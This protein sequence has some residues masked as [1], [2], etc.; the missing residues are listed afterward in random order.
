MTDSSREPPAQGRDPARPQDLLRIGN[1][2]REQVVRRIHDA[3]AEGRLDAEE[4]Q[5]RLDAAYQ[6]KTMGELAPLTADLPSTSAPQRRPESRPRE[7]SR[8]RQRSRSR[9]VRAPG[10]DRLPV[11]RQ[12]HPALRVLW[13]IWATAVAVNVTAWLVVCITTG[14]LVYGWPLWVAGPAGTAL[15]VLTIVTRRQEP[16]TDRES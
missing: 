11:R 10:T 14:D 5:E 13:T 9:P 8:P 1:A 12:V 6:A 15:L 7:R 3:F 4:L 16:G 2:E